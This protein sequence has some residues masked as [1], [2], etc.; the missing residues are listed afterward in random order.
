MTRQLARGT[1]AAL[2]FLTLS[3][4]AAFEKKGTAIEKALGTKKA[5]QKKV[6]VEGKEVGVFFAKDGKGKVS[7]YAIVREALF[8]PSCTHT[9]VIGLDGE[10]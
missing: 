9:W 1:I 8:P 6:K 10:S 3:A 2:L 4:H 5:F 7:R